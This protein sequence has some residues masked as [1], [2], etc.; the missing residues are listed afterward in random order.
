MKGKGHESEVSQSVT[1]CLHE[2]SSSSKDIAGDRSN[3][4]SGLCVIHPSSSSKDFEGSI[5]DHQVSQ[6]AA[7]PVQPVFVEVFAGCCQLSVSMQQAGLH[8]IPVDSS[9]NKHQPRCKVFLLDLNT[10]SARNELKQKIISQS[11]SAIH[12]ALP[13]GNR[14]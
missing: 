10:E 4:Q 14:Q 6:P 8:S 9:K 1:N 5:K 11:V 13:C 2:P 7:T 3:S 12:V